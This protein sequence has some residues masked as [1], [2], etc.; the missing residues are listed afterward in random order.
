MESWSNASHTSSPACIPGT[1]NPAE[2][3]AWCCAQRVHNT[4]VQSITFDN[5]VTHT[6]QSTAHIPLPCRWPR[7]RL[8]N[9]N[10][11]VTVTLYRRAGVINTLTA[12]PNTLRDCPQRKLYHTRQHQMEAST[13]YASSHIPAPDRPSVLQP[14]TQP[15]PVNGDDEARQ[16][17]HDV[18]SQK[19]H[20]VHVSVCVRCWGGVV[21]CSICSDVCKASAKLVSQPQSGA[22]NAEPWYVT[23][24][25][26]PLELLYA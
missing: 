20:A 14:F 3:P 19:C 26:Q 5:A 23:E 6:R 10:C 9:C 21:R 25:L 13:T 22:D 15:T 11:N 24:H 1:G 4:A 2:E 18:A 12:T 7:A 16:C 17:I 8:I